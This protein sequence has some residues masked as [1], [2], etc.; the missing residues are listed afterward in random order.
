MVWMKSAPS[1][2]PVLLV[3]L[4]LIA[5]SVTL[6]ATAVAAPAA[7]GSPA[8]AVAPA[9]ASASKPNLWL[10]LHA[11]PNSAVS[12]AMVTV[13]NKAGRV[14]GKGKANKAGTIMLRV[15]PGASAKNP[16]LVRTSGGKVRGK[17][18]D[19]HLELVITKLGMRHGAHFV[20][21]VTTVASDYVE[22]YGGTLAQAERRAFRKLGLSEDL[23]H[24][25]LAVPT[26]AVHAPALSRHH[27]AKGGF[28]GTVRHLV[29]LMRTA[30]PFPDFGT[31]EVERLG[32][33]G[34]Q[35]RS[36]SGYSNAACEAQ[37]LPSPVADSPATVGV[38]GAMMTAGLVSAYMTKDPSLLLNGVAGMVFS[39]TPGMTNASMLASVQAQLSCISQQITMVAQ[40]LSLQMSVQDAARCESTYVKP[41]WTNYY[42]PLLNAAAQSPT[43]PTTSLDDTVNNAS[44]EPTM[45][46]IELMNQQCGDIIND[47]LFN[48][49]GG[50]QAA[51]PTVLA[52]SREANSAAFKPAALAQLQQFLQ[53]WGNIE[54]QQS[55]MMNDWY[56]YQATVI[57]KPQTTLQNAAIGGNCQQSADLSNTA[58]NQDA[59]TWCQWQQNIVN[60]WPGDVFSDEVADWDLE[61]VQSSSPY[62]ISGSAVSAVPG[63]WGNSTAAWTEDP[64]GLTPGT[65]GTSDLPNGTWKVSNAL[66][67]YNNQPEQ[68]L[69]APYQRYDYRAA[70]KTFAPTR[71]QL[72]GYNNF[73]SFFIGALGATITDD[74]ATPCTE[75]CP[76]WT[77]IG[78]DGKT[79]LEYLDFNSQACHDEQNSQNFKWYYNSRYLHNWVTSPGPWKTDGTG[80]YVGGEVSSDAHNG[81]TVCSHNVPPF[82]WF[83]ARPWTQ[84]ASWPAVPTVTSP[85]SVAANAQ[86]TASGCPD[87][88]CTWA[89]TSGA[90]PGLTVSSSGQLNYTGTSTS[91][92]AKV[93]VAAMNT[94]QASLDK[95]ITVNLTQF[96]PVI[97]TT[98]TVPRN[99][100]LAADHCPTSGCTWSLTGAVPAGISLS[101]SG[102][103]SYTGNGAAGVVA[104]RPVATNS[105]GSSAPGYV[106]VDLTSEAPTVINGGIYARNGLLIATGGG[107]AITWKLLSTT[108]PGVNVN[109][110]GYVIVSGSPSASTAQVTVT[111]TNS[112]GQTSP[113]T[114]LTVS[115]R[116][117]APII[118]SSGTV[119]YGNGAKLT[120]SGC[121]SS[122]CVWSFYGYSQTGQAY[123]LP[124]NDVVLY[125]DGTLKYVGSGGVPTVTVAVITSTA[126]PNGVLSQPVVLKLT[127]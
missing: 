27:K 11:G 31:H 92:T 37:T 21:L 86:L 48:T 35:A 65:L 10:Q 109:G 49:Q 18:F 90:I 64:R 120:A 91:S 119:H 59:S 93:T 53:Y 52:E 45:D 123:P 79:E 7:D 17:A 116:Y 78:A 58:D 127:L 96:Y 51:W 108:V 20:D 3:S 14:V 83:L 40:T 50:V 43:D 24:G 76:D 46:Q 72:D 2:V 25:H 29:K 16:Y 68:V 8:A 9:A 124:P 114:T 6:P 87:S 15:E 54:Y 26:Y 89:I 56:N 117:Y 33:T 23:G 4:G 82:A 97:T 22:E 1:R 98:G 5:G 107:G 36:S 111:A 77:F 115:T 30:K 126:F 55:I 71:S 38:Y 80:T 70:T 84:G 104:I 95:A 112:Y 74:T 103:I 57:R 62:A 94:Y 42:Q 122:G 113:P 121:P 44:L 41:T 66:A 125:A 100:Q 106:Q 60:V 32:G 81:S 63:G 13:T 101:T 12:E 105:V 73:H 85:S 118:T 28:D 88:G 102:V 75:N 67:T 34:A 47:A 61:P 69:S 39:N 19:G 99:T 110:M